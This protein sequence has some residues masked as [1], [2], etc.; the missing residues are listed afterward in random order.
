MK[1]Y[2][3]KFLSIYF[4]LAVYMW[5]MSIAFCCTIVNGNIPLEKHMPIIYFTIIFL[6]IGALIVMIQSTY[7][8][9]IDEKGLIIKNA[10]CPPLEHSFRYDNIEYIEI[11]MPSWHIGFKIHQRDAKPK[12]YPL[13]TCVREKDYP[14]IIKILK[15][16]G[17]EFK[18]K[19]YL[20]KKYL[21]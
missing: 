15:A 18:M 17:V 14:Q 4:W 2:K 11:T 1:F 13:D 19:D 5:G 6:I 16:K 21:K 3:S 10:S 12:F 9:V 20:R 7:Y 8:I